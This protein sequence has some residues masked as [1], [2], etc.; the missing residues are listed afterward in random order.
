MEY[1]A[2]KELEQD[3]DYF[4]FKLRTRKDS[5]DLRVIDEVL[6]NNFYQVP[7]KLKTVIDIGAHIGTFSL[8]AARAGARVYAFEPEGF[9][10][11]TLVHNVEINGYED[12]ITCLK[13]GVGK[14]G[15]NKLYVHPYKTGGSS[16]YV[17]LIRGLERE[18]YQTVDFIS[19][20]DV[21]EFY[22]IRRCDLLKMDCEGSEEDI[23]E[24][25]DDYVKRIDQI[26]AELHSGRIRDKV[27][28]KMS[29][30]YDIECTNRK[31]RVWV[32][33]KK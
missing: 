31:K 15:K 3:K 5:T 23:F 26:S 10:Y 22:N 28:N 6:A 2:T 27:I 33:N 16:M 1:I 14:K 7:S 12:R 18:K 11:K 30:W 8:K 25:I 21:F 13:L 29:K 20:K 32:F 19:I 17:R 24:D 9:N 4:G